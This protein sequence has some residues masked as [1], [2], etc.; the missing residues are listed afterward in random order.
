MRDFN[1]TSG[2][3]NVRLM[4]TKALFG[5]AAGIKIGILGPHAH[6]F[7][8]QKTRADGGEDE[9]AVGV[10]CEFGKFGFECFEGRDA[11]FH[12]GGGIVF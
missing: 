2:E 12:A 5:Q 8:F 1:R 6:V 11:F 9:I 4:M 10:G 7:E 3:A